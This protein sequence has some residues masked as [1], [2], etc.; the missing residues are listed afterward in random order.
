M[1]NIEISELAGTEL[2]QDSESF[3]NELSDREMAIMGGTVSINSFANSGIQSANSA[4]N[5]VNANSNGNNNSVFGS[6]VS[7]KY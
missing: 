3:L 4:G 1:A 6:F 7:R 2:F 5:S